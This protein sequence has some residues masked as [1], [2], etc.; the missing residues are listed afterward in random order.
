MV[1]KKEKI[2]KILLFIYLFYMIYQPNFSYIIHV[3]NYVVY[4]LIT[5]VYLF[6][7]IIK[8]KEAINKSLKNRNIVLFIVLLIMSTSYFACRICIASSINGVSLSFD[9]LRIL[10]GLMPIIYLLGAIMVKNSFERLKYD[11]SDKIDFFLKVALFQSFIAV[12][13]VIFPQLKNIAINIFRYTSGEYNTYIEQGRLYGLCDG[14]YTYG[15]QIFHSIIAFFSF[16]TAYK[17]NRKKYYIYAIILLL[18]TVLNGRSGLLIFAANFI[19]FIIYI[20]FTKAGLLKFIKYT[21]CASIIL[22]TGYFVVVNY[23]PNTY[24]IINHAITDLINTMTG[25]DGTETGRYIEMFILPSG[26]SIIFGMGFRVIGKG[27]RIFGY[28]KSS[29]IGYVNDLFM[30]GIVYIYLLYSSFHKLLCLTKKSDNQAVRIFYPFLIIS[31]GLANFK[32]EIF[33]QSIFISFIILYSVVLGLKND[34]E[35]K[36]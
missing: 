26:L 21:L 14:D 6:Y 4:T 5:L 30:G 24:T 29:D 15:L 12:L 32:G 13:M 1:I 22:L 10:Q 19:L 2:K 9:D 33:R 7:S 31:L 27:G 20:L 11:T 17:S 8:N 25:A 18:V 36:I 34:L 23:L 3:N 16:I 28:M 35:E